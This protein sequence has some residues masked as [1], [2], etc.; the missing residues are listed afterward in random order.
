MYEH[1]E[2]KHLPSYFADLLHLTLHILF[3]EA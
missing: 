2:R 3:S 1:M